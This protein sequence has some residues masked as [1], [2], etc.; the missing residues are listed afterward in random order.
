[1]DKLTVSQLAAKINVT[2]YT[3]K[4]WYKWYEQL[5]PEEL[6]NYLK[7]GMPQLPKYDS[8]GATQWRLWNSEDVN[9]IKKFRDWVPHTRGGVMGS[10]NKKG[11]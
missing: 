11:E 1:M 3:I 7:N 4:R 2:S 8:I 5:T 9:Q 10:L 6:N